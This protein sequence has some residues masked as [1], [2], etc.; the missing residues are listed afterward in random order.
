MAIDNRTIINDCEATTGW[1]GTDAVT[2]VSNTGEFYEGTQGLS[3]QAS[4]SNDYMATTQD[5]VGMGTF[6]NDWSDS[7]LYLL[8]KDNLQDTAANGGVQFVVGDGT[9]LI[10]YDVGGN[11]AVG[12]PFLGAYFNSYKLDMS[13]R[14]ASFTTI[15]GSE[16]NLTTT[17][18]SEIGYG[19]LHLAKANGP[20][21]NVFMDAFRFIAN[22][23]YALTINAGTMGT[24]ETMTDVVADDVTGGWGLVS[25]PIGD[26]YY[27]FGPTEWGEPVANADHYFTASNEQWFWLGDN[28]GGHALGA[29][30]FPFRVIG[31][32][33]DTGSFVIESIVVVNVGTGAEFDCSS[34]DVDTLEISS[35]SFDGL[36]SF[37]AP[38]AGGTS[39]FVTTTSFSNCGLITVPTGSDF[40]NNTISNSS[41]STALTAVSLDDLDSCTFI[42]AGTGHA[43]DLG[44]VTSTTSMNWNCSDS[45]YALVDGSTGNETILVSVNSGQT[46]T[47]NVAAGATTPTIKNDGLGTVSVVSGQVTLTIRAIDINTQANLQ[48]ARVYVTAAAGGSLT[49][50]TVIIDKVLTDVNGEA[51]DTRSYSSDQPVEGVVRLSSTPP[52]YRTGNIV[53]TIDNASGLT[54]TVQMIPDE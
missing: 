31:N 23:S 46:L 26:A 8:V 41:A 50:G 21:D 7:T 19:C 16:A 45:G 14:P 33:T 30:H 22:D 54:I 18:I 24:P 13:N 44:T 52:F 51:S 6:S 15:S 37:D 39:R 47:I 5:S 35:S 49:V 32:A 42:S 20:S 10:G 9:D 4:N 53:G 34:A 12:L 1:S 38:A 28:G 43:V 11:D 2:S 25:N 27:F 17:A 29:T 36:A 48:G 3:W 40:S